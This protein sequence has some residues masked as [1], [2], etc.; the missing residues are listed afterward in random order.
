[1]LLKILGI[2]ESYIMLVGMVTGRTLC[3]WLCPD[4]FISAHK[5]LPCDSFVAFPDGA[6]LHLVKEALETFAVMVLDAGDSAE[7]FGNF[8]K[9]FSQ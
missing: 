3:R 2:V 4:I 9:T 8:G 7:M 6:F 5:T 1:M